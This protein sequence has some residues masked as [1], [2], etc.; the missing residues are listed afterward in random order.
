MAV[1]F[2]AWLRNADVIDLLK[3]AIKT[4]RPILL[5]FVNLC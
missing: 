1:G 5:R 2:R 4:N 3:D